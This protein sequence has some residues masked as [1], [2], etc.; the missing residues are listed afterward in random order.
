MKENY[1]RAAREIHV[2]STLQHENVLELIGLA[3]FRDQL[4]MIS[5]WM[6]GGVLPSYL[7]RYPNVNRLQL[8]CSFTVTTP[9]PLTL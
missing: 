6:G 2:W 8:V 3:L 4:S 5:P 7:E 1:Q 9:Q